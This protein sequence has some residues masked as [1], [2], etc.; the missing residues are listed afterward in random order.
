MLGILVLP[1]KNDKCFQFDN[2]VS[3]PN[4]LGLRLGN[5][6]VDYCASPIL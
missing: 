6:I 1:A 2:I 5:H 4:F 3:I